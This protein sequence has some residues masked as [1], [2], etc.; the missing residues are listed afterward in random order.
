[1]DEPDK[2]RLASLLRENHRRLRARVLIQAW[3]SRGVSASRVSGERQEQMLSDL[4]EW[5]NIEYVPVVDI[6]ALLHGFVGSASIVAV[7][8][9]SPHEAPVLIVPAMALCRSED[10]LH[11]LYP[12][13]MV[14]WTATAVLYIDIDHEIGEVRACRYERLGR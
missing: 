10:D 14:V 7:A 1:M 11:H 9:W 4:R 8:E 5:R 2:E 12:D 3:A 6:V 13:G